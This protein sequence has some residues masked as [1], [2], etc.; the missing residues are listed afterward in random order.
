MGEIRRGTRKDHYP[1]PEHNLPEKA[2]GTGSVEE[3][4]STKVESTRR[5][6]HY[7]EFTGKRY[8]DPMMYPVPYYD[9]Y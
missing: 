2:E 1:P 9:D 6:P 7:R 3:G 5:K 8:P 4:L